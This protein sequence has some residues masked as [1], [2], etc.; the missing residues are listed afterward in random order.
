MDGTAT[1]AA[2]I[3]VRASVAGSGALVPVSRRKEPGCP[4]GDR[5][6]PGTPALDGLD[7]S[8]IACPA[9][10]AGILLSRSAAS[11]VAVVISRR[12]R[13]AEIRCQPSMSTGHS[14][15]RSGSPAS[16]LAAVA[17]GWGRF[18]RPGRLAV[19]RAVLVAIAASLV[20]IGSG[21]LLLAAGGR[22]RRRAPP[23]STRR[24]RSWPCPVARFPAAFASRR[25][26]RGGR[27]WP[28]AR[29]ARRAPRPDRLTRPSSPPM[30]AARA[31][32]ARQ[33]PGGRRDVGVE[34]EPVVG[35]PG[36]LD[37][38]EPLER[39]PVAGPRLP[40]PSSSRPGKFR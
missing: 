24:R 29:R 11:G 38:G 28:R 19:D 27:R 26:A 39:R 20:A 30:G 34:A 4:D 9:G 31:G 32:A 17:I 35:V 2:S 10:S 16:S 33:A 36:G 6:A 22:A 13:A 40:S 15:S 21:L 8:T 7:R 12:S 1:A 14:P 37:L 23:R 5:G 18:G 25:G 3:A